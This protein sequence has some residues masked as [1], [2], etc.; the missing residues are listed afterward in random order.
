MTLKLITSAVFIM[1]LLNSCYYNN[2]KELHPEGAL[3][4]SNCDTL[5]ATSYST[6]IAPIISSYCTQCHN[7]N[8]S[9]HNISTWAT[10][11]N[12]ALSGKLYGSVA[13]DGS[14]LEMPTGGPKISDCDIAKI[15]LWAAAG[16][17][18]N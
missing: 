5:A 18:N 4:V 13:R 8:G 2:F 12:D 17:P 14:A 9:A 3:S 6:H 7:A 16:A 10:A 11:K 1:L 15:K